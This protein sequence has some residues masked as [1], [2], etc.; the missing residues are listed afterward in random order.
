MFSS[1]SSIGLVGFNL[2]SKTVGLIGTGQIGLATA[3]ILS[4]GFS[5]KVIAY[6]PYPNQAAAEKYGFSYIP[7]LDQLLEE[8]DI[9]SLHCPLMES[10]HHI[11]NHET[12]SKTKKGV[13]LINVARGALIQTKALIQYVLATYYSHMTGTDNLLAT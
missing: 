10:T 8:S 13:F 1:D 11:L 9:V 4:H 12:L 6:D 3:K 7:T 5:S 2:Q